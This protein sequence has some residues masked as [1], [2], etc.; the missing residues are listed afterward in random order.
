MLYLELARR[1]KGWSQGDLGSHPKVRIDRGFISMIER[2]L[3]LPVPEQV[4]RLSLALDVAPDVLLETV[5][6]VPKD[7]P[8]TDDASAAVNG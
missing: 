6:A 1:Q 8:V 7:L 5:P 2:G 4:A 3:A